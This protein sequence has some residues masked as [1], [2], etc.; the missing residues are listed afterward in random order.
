MGPSSALNNPISEVTA[1]IKKVSYSKK[2]TKFY[3][4]STKKE[5][6]KGVIDNLDGVKVYYN[7]KVTNVH[8]RNVTRDGYNL[9]LRYQCVEFVKRYYYEY[10]RHKM[11]N[12]YGHAREFYDLRIQGEGFNKARGLM[13]YS[14]GGRVRPRKGDIIVFGPYPDN[15]FGHI[16]IISSVTE[17]SVEIIQQNVDRHTRAN[18]R[19]VSSGSNFYI[20]D[21]Q[22]LG[23]LR[24]IK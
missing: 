17:K 16:G 1:N 2:A 3:D 6:E 12:S 5:D 9:G 19:T 18:Y 11:P 24:K 8:G 21:I 20:Q 7:G 23:W 14:N 22:V 13:Q 4:T 10:Y 15:Q